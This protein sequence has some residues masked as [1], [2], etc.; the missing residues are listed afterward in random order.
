MKA[1]T[2][3]RAW[4]SAMIV[5]ADGGLARRLRA[6]D[7]GDAAAR[8]AADSERQ[9]EG[10]RPGRDVVDLL[11]LARASFMIA[12]DRTASRCSSSAAST[13]L[14][15]SLSD[16]SA[17]FSAFRS[18]VIAISPSRSSSICAT[19]HRSGRDG[20]RPVG[21]AF[22]LSSRRR[23][24]P[25]VACGSP[26][27]SAAVPRAATS[28]VG[29]SS[30]SA[31]SASLRGRFRPTWLCLAS[32][33]RLR[34]DPSRGLIGPFTVAHPA[35]ASTNSAIDAGKVPALMEALTLAIKSRVKVR[36]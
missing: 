31:S 10:D 26:R 8:D 5:L 29:R 33:S 1:A 32:R 13:A 25:C 6:E 17:A 21:Q 4:A 27:R 18:S 22:P 34:V 14:P 24:F 16:R 23:A 35:C 9:V 19:G 11:Q 12:R 30:P 36:L 15:R 3:P 2:P 20:V 28:S 7:L